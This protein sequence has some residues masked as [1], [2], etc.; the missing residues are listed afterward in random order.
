[1]IFFT[2][3]LNLKKKSFVG[4]CSSGGGGGG[5]RRRGVDGWTEE[6][7]QTDLP[8]QLLRIWGIKIHKCT[9]YVPD[10]LNL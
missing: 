5:G 4:G 8:L 10:K 9:C 1:M 7:A 3:N 2:N 6:Q